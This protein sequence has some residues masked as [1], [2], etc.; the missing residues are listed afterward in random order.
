M[1]TGDDRTAGPAAL[2][3]AAVGRMMAGVPSSY[4]I[5]VVRS[6]A[7][8][9]QLRLGG[10]GLEP[11]HGHNWKVAV[12]VASDRLDALGCVMDFHELERLTD[13]VVVPLHNRHLNDVP[14]FDAEL[15]PSAENVAVHVARSVAAGLPAGASVAK[16]R[17]WETAGN[18]A[19]YR[20]ERSPFVLPTTV[21]SLGVKCDRCDR[22][23]TVHLSQVDAGQATERHLCDDCMVAESAYAPS[24]HKPIGE[25]LADLRRG[26]PDAG[27]AEGV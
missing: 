5:R 2:P 1:R 9:H 13:A 3:A 10:G 19:E 11:L 8:S 22:P 15:N 16:V 20:P 23:A 4:S 25:L 12:T 27:A 7:A 14:P 18:S 26:R 6:F 24:P 21:R 17:A